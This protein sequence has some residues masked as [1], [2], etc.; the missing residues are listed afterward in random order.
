[1]DAVELAK[2]YA[3]FV[4]ALLLDSG[5]TK[6]P[7]KELGGTGRIHDWDISQKIVGSVDIPVFLAGGIHSGNIQTAIRA[8]KPYG[9]DL[10][11]GV[12]TNGQLDSAKLKSLFR[13]AQ[14]L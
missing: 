3:P 5:N 7:I 9:I 10:C 6:L 4:D 2:C 8:V 13:A 1:M 12:R 14:N 11:S